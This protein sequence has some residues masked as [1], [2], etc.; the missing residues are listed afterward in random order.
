VRPVGA[1]DVVPPA[2]VIVEW[3]RPG[4]RRKDH[5]ARDKL[6]GRRA[7]KVLFEW[8]ALG[9]RDVVGRLDKAGELFIRDR[10]LVDPESVQRDLVLRLRLADLRAAAPER[11]SRNPNH[12]GRTFADRLRRN[13][14]HSDEG[15]GRS[16]GSHSEERQCQ[17]F[18]RIAN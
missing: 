18:P 3:D 15:I 16:K 6:F 2:E 17:D 10:G 14:H 12:A 4:R 8:R 1:F 9:D 13:T 11:P 5:S 7:G